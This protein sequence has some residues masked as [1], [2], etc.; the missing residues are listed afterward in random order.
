[1]DKMLPVIAFKMTKIASYV[2]DYCFMEQRLF[3]KVSNNN[4]NNN[5]NNNRPS[6]EELWATSV[7]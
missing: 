1:M 2:L 7:L 6:S 5:S 4:T 3:W